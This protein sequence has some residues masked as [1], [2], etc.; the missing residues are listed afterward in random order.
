VLAR[1]GCGPVTRAER[2]PA[3]DSES[4]LRPVVRRLEVEL[5]DP[6]A[7]EGDDH[8]AAVK[9]VVALNGVA[10]PLE[11]V[12]AMPYGTELPFHARPRRAERDV[13]DPAPRNEKRSD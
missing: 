1:V 11:H 2:D 5:P 6:A 13:A 7:M 12:V 4:A 9:P 3:S 8:S 10:A